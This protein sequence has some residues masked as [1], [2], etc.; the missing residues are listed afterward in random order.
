MLELG[1]FEESLIMTVDIR[2]IVWLQVVV[3][4]GVLLVGYMSGG[5]QSEGRRLTKGLRIKGTLR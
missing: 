2:F 3:V 4:G 1:V 5:S